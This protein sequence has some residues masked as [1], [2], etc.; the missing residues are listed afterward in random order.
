MAFVSVR[1]VS[2]GF[3]GPLLLDHIT[4]HIEHGERV[5]LLGRN[6]AGKSTLLKLIGGELLPDNGVIARQQARIARLPQKSPPDLRGR[7]FDIAIAGLGARGKLLAEYSRA[8]AQLAHNA[9]GAALARLDQLH[10]QLDVKEA[11]QLNQKVE[12]VLTHLSLDASS[13]FETLSGGQKRRVLLA[14]ALTGQPDLLLLDEPTNHLDIPS[15][16]WLEAYLLR[17]I[18]TLLF[19]SHDRAFVRKLATRVIELDRGKLYDWGCDYDTFVRRKKSAIEQEAR[20][21]QE[22]AK[23]LAKEETWIRQGTQARTTRNQGRVKSL[24]QMRRAR[25]EQREREG[26]VKMRVQTAGRTGKMVIEATKVDFGYGDKQIVR[27]LTTTI[28]RGDKV[29]IIGP[30]GSGKTTLLRLLLGELEPDAGRIR[31]GA[32]VQVSYFDQMRD[33]LDPNGTVQDNVN[34]G[35]P[36][37]DINGKTQHIIGYLRNFLFPPERIQVKARDLS[38][39]ERTRLMLARLFA[40]PFNV[41]VM[42][43]PTNDLDLETLELLEQLL[44]QYSGTLL[45]VSHDR[46]LLNNVVAYT[47]ALGDQGRVVKYAGGYDDWLW[48]RPAAPVETR[49]RQKPKGETRRKLA[50]RLSFEE[51]RELEDLPRRIEEIEAEQQQLYARLSDPALY[52]NDG[53]QVAGLQAQL[54]RLASSLETA[55]QRWEFLESQPQRPAAK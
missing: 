38:G 6:G 32:H 51:Q 47:L 39:G 25:R 35:N 14:R 45:L 22:F 50:P 26:A 24:E 34:D 1:E 44:I 2:H 43:E 29:G 3:G 13:V 53:A 4:L 28:E 10:R 49:K 42:D 52:Q 37:L 55:Y 11:W 21:R 36:Y 23:T 12:R 5:C 30:N 48:Q 33:Q 7:V 18:D 31:H 19:V 20:E 46:A 54:A 27:D 41:L 9:T 40:H 17:H 8:S 15:I 16:E